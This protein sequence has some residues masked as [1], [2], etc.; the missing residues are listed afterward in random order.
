MVGIVSVECF[1]MVSKKVIFVA[2]IHCHIAAKPTLET[3]P[4]QT[5]GIVTVNRRRISMKFP[6]P[7]VRESR[8]LKIRW[9]SGSLRLRITPTEL[10]A[11]HRGEP[12]EERLRIPGSPIGGGWNVILLPGGTQS[13]I[14]ASG[15][16]VLFDISRVD[17]ERLSDSGA[18]G[19]YCHRYGSAEDVNGFSFYV[20]KDFPCVHPRPAEANEAQTETFSAPNGF[21][22]RKI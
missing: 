14:G 9:T 6:S 3:I 17:L 12:V 7:R 4:K 13:D 5:A 16:T 8:T 18:E 1:G 22:E 10:N 11:L 20:E 15:G 19:I 2:Y 21:A